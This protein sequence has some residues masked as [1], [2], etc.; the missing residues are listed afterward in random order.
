[1]LMTFNSLGFQRTHEESLTPLSRVMVS[2]EHSRNVCNSRRQSFVLGCKYQ[3]LEYYHAIIYLSPILVFPRAGALHQATREGGVAA[4]S[5]SLTSR[6][7][8]GI[9]VRMNLIR[10][11][12][13]TKSRVIAILWTVIQWSGVHTHCN[14][15]SFKTAMS[16]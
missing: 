10:L 11:T 12:V 9:G 15:T 13:L 14:M 7:A 1:M 16:I 8:G 4:S 3:V 2:F 5:C 6:G